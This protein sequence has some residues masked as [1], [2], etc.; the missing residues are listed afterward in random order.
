MEIDRRIEGL[1]FTSGKGN[2]KGFQVPLKK[3]VEA[4]MEWQ[5]LCANHP[6]LWL[7]WNVDPDWCIVQQRLVK[8][9]GWTPLVGSDPRAKPP[10]LIDGA[11]H[12]NFNK[13]IN[14]P[15]FHMI[16]AIEFAFLYVPDKL[17]FWHSDLLVRRE[18]L[19]HIE[20]TI[21]R[22]TSNEMLV[23]QPERGLKARLLCQQKRYWELLG[24]TNKHISKHQFLR[25]SGW[26]SNIMYHPLSP[27]TLKEKKR[28]AK[29]YY[30]H[31]TGI[32]YWAKHYKPADHSIHLIPEA[33]L[34]EGHFSRIR[35]K[36]YR[37]I[38]PNNSRRDLTSELSLNFDI[39]KETA[40]LGLSDLVLALPSETQ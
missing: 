38:S 12:V 25:G 36:K 1:S 15:I 2:W 30:D 17:A 23:T 20:Q 3:I 32:H 37:T 40:R 39:K 16:I 4:S 5:A 31:G 26:M 19:R 9:L 21:R 18:K 11:I 8:E 14:L 33:L 7:C 29:Q 10:T 13:H 6:K 22:M 24:C 35:A 28:R 34:D 27:Q